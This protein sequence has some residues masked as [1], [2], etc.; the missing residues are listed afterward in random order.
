MGHLVH[1][2]S[3]RHVQA[4]IPLQ[5]HDDLPRNRRGA[6]LHQLESC[7]LRLYHLR[8][9]Y[10]STPERMTRNSLITPSRGHVSRV[11]PRRVRHFIAM[12]IV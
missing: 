10:T 1:S 9:M 12:S 5:L 6:R 7:H 3:A 11:N 2:A 8:P 4:M